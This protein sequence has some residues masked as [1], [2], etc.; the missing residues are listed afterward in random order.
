M[1]TH[2]SFLFPGPLRL[3]ALAAALGAALL[4]GQ[5][6]AQQP[7]AGESTLVKLI[8]G[9]ID[10]G[11]LEPEAGRALLAEAARE[12]AADRATAARP[13]PDLQ[14]GDVRVP[15][16]PQTVRDEI[17]EEVKAEVL[18]QAREER[19]AAP[20][21]VPA[22]TQRLE[23]Q[24]DVRVRNES[25]LYSERNSDIEVDWPRINE[26]AGYDVNPNT[27]LQLP[28]LRN[29]R[30]DRNNLWRVR[31]RLG[32]TATLGEQVRAGIRLASGNDDGPVSATQALGG[33]LEKKDAWLDQ[34][35]L[36]WTPAD[37]LEVIGGRFDNPY[38]STDMLFSNDL[39]FDGLA[40][41]YAQ[42][43]GA[44]GLSLF[45]NLGLTPL[46]Y[47]SDSFP[48]NSQDKMKSN[49]KWLNGLQVGAQWAFADDHRLRGALAYYDFRNIAGRL[50]EPC[51]LY[52][53]ADH[54]STDWT[55]PAFMQKGNTLMLLRDI[56]L[57]PLD[58]ANTAMPQYA[59]LASKFELL[60]VNLRW[61]L[62]A[63][64]GHALRLEANWL[65]NLGFD[66]RR[67]WDRANGGIVTNIATPDGAAPSADDI[68]SGDVAWMAQATFGAP[69][70]RARGDWHAWLG[71]KRIEP[72]ALP[73][74]YNDPNF[75]L[76]GTNAKGYYLGGSWMFERNVWLTGRWMAA[77]EAMGAPLSIDVFQLEVNAGF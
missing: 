14:P 67:M 33:G 23:V 22:W 70:L 19:W 76:G 24:G 4:S 58:P 30:E 61:E 20:D 45:A 13:A 28:P 41:R 17:R 5:A 62:P 31:A 3:A 59:G 73:D 37:W 55:R 60:D 71:Y 32:V 47:T 72:D 1:T 54:C 2:P 64:A 18:A 77:K 75:H 48:G 36:S 65:Q 34:V 56:A 50:S 16:V 38:W 46:E 9:L 35:W 39:A 63:F 25:R 21:A 66:R 40:I 44:D 74:G 52:A 10:S 6:R 69:A 57:D 51:A 7:E 43:A 42:D 26:G 29:T 53:G 11:A 49:D 8:R 15:Y 12:A 27:N 68:V